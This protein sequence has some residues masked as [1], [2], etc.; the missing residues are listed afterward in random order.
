MKNATTASHLATIW[1]YSD[2]TNTR[3]GLVISDH[4]D[5]GSWESFQGFDYI[6]GSKRGKLVIS[7]GRSCCERYTS[8]ILFEGIAYFNADKMPEEVGR[9]IQQL[10]ITHISHI[11]KKRDFYD[12]ESYIEL[13]FTAFIPGETVGDGRT[14]SD[15]YLI[16]SNQ[17]NGYYPHEVIAMYDDK[18]HSTRI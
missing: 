14:Q 9:R 18:T 3:T 11:V 16:A 6:L 10:I 8:Y 7:S 5:S 15:L 17:H 2:N 1:G 13:K 12:D 4:F